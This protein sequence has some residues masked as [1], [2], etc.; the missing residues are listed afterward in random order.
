[1]PKDETREAKEKQL[2]VDFSLYGAGKMDLDT[3]RKVR[4]AQDRACAGRLC[5]AEQSSCQACECSKSNEVL[6]ATRKRMI[7]KDAAAQ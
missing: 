6:F 2:A 3:F 1:M 4:T 7:R 5:F